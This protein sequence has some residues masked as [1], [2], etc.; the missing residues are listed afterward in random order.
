MSCCGGN[1]DH[2]NHDGGNHVGKNSRGMS[3]ALRMVLCCGLPILLFALVPVIGRL[4][5]GIGAFIQPY[6]FLLCPLMMVGMTL[7]MRKG[8]RDGEEIDDREG[9]VRRLDDVR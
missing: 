9:T 7:M 6:A 5:G 1:H 4:T 8:H 3:H 2:G